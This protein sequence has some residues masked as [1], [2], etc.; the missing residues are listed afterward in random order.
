LYYG[1]RSTE[2]IFNE[3]NLHKDIDQYVQAVSECFV[4]VVWFEDASLCDQVIES[5]FAVLPVFPQKITSTKTGN[6]ISTNRPCI[7]MAVAPVSSSSGLCVI[8]IYER[9]PL[10]NQ[11]EKIVFCSQ[12]ISD[13]WAVI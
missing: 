11:E 3:R 10:E 8:R 9:F 7:A 4:H 1:N 6:F 2:I 5:M 13:I 12:L